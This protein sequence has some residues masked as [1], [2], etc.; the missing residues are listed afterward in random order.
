MCNEISEK[1]KLIKELSDKLEILKEENAKV[2]KF[3]YLLLSYY[4]SITSGFV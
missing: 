3:I 4:N 1:E 2:C